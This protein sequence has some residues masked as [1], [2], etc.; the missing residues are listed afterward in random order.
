MDNTLFDKALNFAAAKHS[1][2]QR[3]N[4]AAPYILHPL[5]VAVIAGSITSDIEILAAAVLHDTVE[6][7]DTSI[8][9]IEQTFGKRVSFL[10]KAETENKRPEKDPAL[11]WTL[12][13]EESIQEL[14]NTDDIGVKIIWLADK[15]SNMRSFYS[16]WKTEGDKLWNKFNQK[17]PALQ[18][19]YYRAVKEA[20]SLLKDTDA[21]KEYDRLTEIVFSNV[22]T[23]N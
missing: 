10:V 1:G 8:E 3:K 19:W 15:L 12:R 23:E 16:A 13:K 22:K 21:W 2:M 18:A 14:K 4:S 5:E 7:T 11:T 17:D 6:D 20:V 9:E